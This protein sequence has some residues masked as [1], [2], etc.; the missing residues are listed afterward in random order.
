MVHCV[1][2]RIIHH[3]YKLKQKNHLRIDA[4]KAFDEIQR[5]F[6]LSGQET[7]RKGEL[8]ELSKHTKNLWLTSH[9]EKLEAFSLRVEMKQRDPL[10]PCLW[11]FGN[12]PGS[13]S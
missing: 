8:S 7:T 11:T 10:S 3:A 1:K 13:P 12:N 5:L 9:Y 4:E 6:V 2:I